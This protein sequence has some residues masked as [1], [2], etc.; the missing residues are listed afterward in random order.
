MEDILASIREILS[1]ET[2]KIGSPPPAAPSVTMADVMPPPVQ[3]PPPVYVAPPPAPAPVYAPAAA[4]SIID[5]IPTMLV[6][7]GDEPM[8]PIM[9]PKNF[10]ATV[11]LFSDLAKSL[12]DRQSK[13]G[14]AETTIEDV[15]KDI[16]KPLVKDWLDANL[17][18]M[19]ETMVRHE[20]EKA[21]ARATL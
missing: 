5:L 1:D 8:D 7:K 3:A 2:A 13:V 14:H 17:P 19:V 16:V 4:P 9:S 21:S 10:N 15:V 20:I 11:D 12:Q 6:S 18:R